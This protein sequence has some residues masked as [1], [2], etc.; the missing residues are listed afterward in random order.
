MVWM[1]ELKELASGRAPTDQ[2]VAFGKSAT[3]GNLATRLETFD[4]IADRAAQMTRD[5]VGMSYLDGYVRGINAATPADVG[6]AAAHY[7]DPAH[8]VIV[9]VGDRKMIE[10]PLREMNIAPVAIVDASGNVVR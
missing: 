6:G 9:V 8:T 10:A 5:H 7:F 4:A 1:G 3:A 2:E